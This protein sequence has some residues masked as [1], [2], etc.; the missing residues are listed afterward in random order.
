M[1]DAPANSLLARFEARLGLAADPLDLD[2][3]GAGEADPVEDLA[4]PGEVDRPAVADGR[5][6][7]VLEAAAVVLDVDVADQVLDLLQLVGRVDALVVIG[8]VAGVEVEPDVG[9]V[10]LAPSAPAWRRRSGSGPCG[11]RGRR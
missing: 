6:V 1:R 9:M 3:V 8:D 11:F 4:D 5:E 7:P 2:R 10:D